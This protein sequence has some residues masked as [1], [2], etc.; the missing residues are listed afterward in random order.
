MKSSKEKSGRQR[1]NIVDALR[2]QANAM[3]KLA[4][5][6]NKGDDPL[7]KEDHEMVRMALMPYLT[8]QLDMIKYDYIAGGTNFRSMIDEI[9]SI[10]DY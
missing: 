5:A 8:E 4:E 1:I 9:H 3:M 7:T 2:E 10:T 6:W